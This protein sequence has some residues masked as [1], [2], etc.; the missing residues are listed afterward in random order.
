MWQALLA[1]A[2]PSI[3]SGIGSMIGHHGNRN[4]P[5]N[6]SNDMNNPANSAM[7]YLNQI[8]GKTEQYFKPYID[9]GQQNANTLQGQYDQMTGNTGDF[10]N[11]MG[12]GYQESP[13]FKLRLQRALQGIGNASAAGGMGGSQA[14]QTQQA[15]QAALMSGD[16]YEKYMNHMMNIFGRGQQG[17]EHFNDQGFNASTEYGN[18]MGNVLGTQAQYAYGGQDAQNKARAQ[19]QSNATGAQSN[20]FGSLGSGIQA[21]MNTPMFQQWMQNQTQGK[22]N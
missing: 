5:A 17:M 10:Y 14:D 4:T 9:R 2:A 11:K 18:N 13:G 12:S 6:F 21:M 15:E 1:A 7:N 3:I 16:D 8:P 22:G 19:N 20:L